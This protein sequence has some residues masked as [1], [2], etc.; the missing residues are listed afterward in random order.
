MIEIIPWLDREFLFDQPVGVFPALLERLRGTPARATE[1]ISAVPEET[2]ATPLHGKWSV[3]EHLGDL[4]DLQPPD[5]QRLR[6]FLDRAQVLSPADMGNRRKENANHRQVPVSE[7]L[8][9]LRVGRYELVCRL[10]TLTEEEVAITAL[11]PR[12]QRAMHLLD[13]AYCVADHGDHH[14]AHAARAIRSL[15]RDSSLDGVSGGKEVENCH[16]R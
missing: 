16:P 13:W 2:L 10:E 6:E 9:Q 4:V 8:K 3:K 14:L 15:N 11:H 7:V 12:L 5:E 1:L